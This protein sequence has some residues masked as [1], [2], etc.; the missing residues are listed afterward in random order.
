MPSSAGSAIANNS[1]S[2][3]GRLSS[4]IMSRSV[5]WS[6]S[7]LRT[8]ERFVSQ[9]SRVVRLA[10]CWKSAGRPSIS[11]SF[12]RTGTRSMTFREMERLGCSTR[13]TSLYVSLIAPKIMIISQLTRM[14]GPG[15][16]IIMSS[17]RVHV[18]LITTGPTSTVPSTIGSLNRLS[19]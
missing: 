7:L 17:S 3:S 13:M 8:K 9:S 6:G 4:V 16:S 10:T 1:L 19:K 12:P 15:R 14:R 11:P 5:S 2:S 18:S